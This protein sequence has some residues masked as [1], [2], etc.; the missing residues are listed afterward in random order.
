MKMRCN[1]KEG[2]TLIELVM[3]IA[4]IGILIAIAVP[5]VSST[6]RFAQDS[7]AQGH[8]QIVAAALENYATANNGSYATAESQLTGATPPY[9]N[10]AYCGQTIQGFGYGCTLAATGYT[11]TA[12]P[13][14][15]GGS[16][17]NNYQ[18]TTGGILTA[19][20]CS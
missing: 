5:K 17:S 7:A 10:R 13:S 16:G 18:V 12:T 2:F 20:A 1:N 6:Q 15:C 9:L 19:A 3:V 8:L 14:S 11:I 4:I